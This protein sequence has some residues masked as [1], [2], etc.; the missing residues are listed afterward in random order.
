[1]HLR[2]RAHL[3]QA[4]AVGRSSGLLRSVWFTGVGNEQSISAGFGHPLPLLRSGF[5]WGPPGA[6]W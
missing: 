2:L 4:V 3:Q 6:V 5:W 1:M